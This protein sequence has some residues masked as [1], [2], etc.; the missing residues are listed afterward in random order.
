MSA[1]PSRLKLVGISKTYPGIK[2]LDGVT[3]DVQPG[4][5]HGILGENGAG[6][7]TLLN[8]LSAVIRPDEG[9]VEIDGRPVAIA[10]PLDARRAGI[11]MIH[12]ELQHV[13]HLTVAQNMFLGRPLRK[14]RG[15]LV[16]R[17]GQERRAAEVLRDLDP[18][19]DPRTPIREL[20]VAQQQVVEIARALLEDARVIAMDEPTSSLTPA[21]FDRLAVL[22]AQLAS[23]GVSIIYVSHK[24]DEVFRVCDRATILRDGKFVDTVAIADI[25]EAGIVARMVGREVV[26]RTHTS[27]QAGEVLLDVAD[28]GRDEA[29]RGATFQLRRGEVLGISGLVGSGR[30]E[31]LR[32]IA[33]IDRPTS[34]RIRMAGRPLA[35]HDPRAAIRSGIGLVPEDRKGHGIIRERSVAAN[36]ALPS[37][38]RFSRY[39]LLRKRHRHQVAVQVMTDLRLRPLDVNRPIGKFSGGNQQ[40]AI[41]GRWIAAGAEVLLFDEPTRGIDVGAKSEIY[42]L[43][44]RLASEGRAVIVVSSEMLE[45]MRVSDRVM[46][47]REGRLVATLERDQISEEAIAAHAIPQSQ[48]GAA[49]ASPP[50]QR[51]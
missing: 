34:G 11:A 42:A 33:G 50:A 7:S 18:T 31:L 46:V 29:V 37:M 1:P 13:P 41:I 43:I 16:D 45:I 17:S 26:H 4:E 30:T 35:L 12:Q 3:L 14:A 44:E 9:R 19:I 22:I 10:S 23:R 36:M 6:K 27:H 47:M 20:K 25:D 48:R 28:L 5:V 39:G 24:M 15:L 49:G 21:E 38:G 32:L 51:T 8:V 40:K 2:A